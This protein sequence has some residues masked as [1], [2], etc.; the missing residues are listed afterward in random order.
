MTASLLFLMHG[1]LQQEKD[2]RTQH[3]RISFGRR[4]KSETG[5]LKIQTM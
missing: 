5:L 3:T 1:I 2:H 4:F